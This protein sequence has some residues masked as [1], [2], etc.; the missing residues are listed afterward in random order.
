[1]TFDRPDGPPD[2][3]IGWGS[4]VAAG[5][6]CRLGLS[7]ISLNPGASYR[8]LHDSLLNFN[9]NRDPA[10]LLCLHEDH[11]AGI[12]HGYAKVTGQS[13]GCALHSK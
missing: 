13:M 12:A 5:M 1:M 7:Y 2:N 9:G 3:R 8:G 6:L 11:A 10:T 4:D